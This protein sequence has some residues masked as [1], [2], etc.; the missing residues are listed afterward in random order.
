MGE[1]FTFP[2]ILSKSAK[3]VLKQSL[4]KERKGK[5]K[6]VNYIKKEN[7]KFHSFQEWQ[8]SDHSLKRL[9]EIPFF[10]KLKITLFE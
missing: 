5:K 4:K 6:D 2:K 3:K 10:F 7:I 8:Y 1:N 9:S